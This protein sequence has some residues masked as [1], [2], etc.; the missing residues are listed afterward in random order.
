MSPRGSLPPV[1]SF[2]GERR[3]PIYC[4]LKI[5]QAGGPSWG[6]EGAC[7]S[8]GAWRPLLRSRQAL[9]GV[10][11]G[12]GHRSS[13]VIP[14]ETE[15]MY[16]LYN[17]N[18][19]EHLHRE[20]RRA[21]LPREGRLSPSTR[22]DGAEDRHPGLPALQPQRGRPP[23]HQFQQGERDHLLCRLE[24]RDRLVLE[25][26]S[27]PSLPPVQLNAK[28]GAQHNHTTSKAENGSPREGWLNA[29]G[30][31]GTASTGSAG[32]LADAYLSQAREPHRRA[33]V[34]G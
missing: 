20:R 22:L 6:R 25:R 17:P 33:R 13:E 11:G 19:G 27:R 32:T 23:L 14:A 30:P 21:R 2:A 1:D 8:S 3:T 34:L 28:A 18:S 31:A 16:R 7:A 10:A 12:V 9:F 26:H 4:F 15:P 29:E 5:G 24:G